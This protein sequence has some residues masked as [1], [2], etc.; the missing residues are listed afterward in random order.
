MYWQFYDIDPRNALGYGHIFPETDEGR[1]LCIVY[2]LIGI[3][4]LLVFMA[5]IGDLMAVAT[6]WVYRWK[7][8]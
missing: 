3:P 8:F 1:M 2:S 7:R 6:R 4:L 5:N